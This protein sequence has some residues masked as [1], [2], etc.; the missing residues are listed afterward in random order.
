MSSSRRNG[1]LIGM[2]FPRIDV[3]H[4][5]KAWMTF[6]YIQTFAFYRLGDEILN[7]P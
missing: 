4:I 2:L 3:N 5:S 6:S 7:V 1:L